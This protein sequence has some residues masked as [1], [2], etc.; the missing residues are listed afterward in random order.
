MPVAAEY[1]PRYILVC[2]RWL[3]R[4]QAADAHLDHFALTPSAGFLDPG[5][6]G[7]PG[8]IAL[9]PFPREQVPCD[10]ARHLHQRRRPRWLFPRHDS[11]MRNCARSETPTS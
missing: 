4:A 2:L 11:S 3:Q 6:P 1:P 7:P 8:T 9:V 5:H 10:A